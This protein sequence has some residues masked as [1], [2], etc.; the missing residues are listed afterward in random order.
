MRNVDIKG[1]HALADRWSDKVFLVVAQPSMDTPI[2]EV[3]PETGIGRIRT[4]HRNLLLPVPNLP[5]D[6]EVQP[7][8][9]PRPRRVIGRQEVNDSRTDLDSDGST[10]GENSSEYGHFV[11]P[12]PKSHDQ[13]L[14]SVGSVDVSE[15]V[16]FWLED[17]V[18]A[19]EPIFGHGEAV[20]SVISRRRLV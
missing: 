15:E 2:F 16:N 14:D 6:I 3:K 11:G 5:L 1:T 20:G 17:N 13:Q 8:P 10:F 7:K 4:L 12:V 19:E 9:K 18:G